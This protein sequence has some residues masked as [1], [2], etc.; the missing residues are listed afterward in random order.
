MTEVK[1]EVLTPRGQSVGGA[2]QL[3][4]MLYEIIEDF[5]SEV[6]EVIDHKGGSECEW[7]PMNV[8]LESESI[9]PDQYSTI[10]YST[11]HISQPTERHGN[12]VCI[13]TKVESVKSHPLSS[14]ET[15]DVRLLYE[16]VEEDIK[17]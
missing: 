2:N 16:H 12:T 17:V 5:K 9:F 14:I 1:K 15:V 4:V 7:F 3:D 6:K 11:C 13:E 8:K 10:Q